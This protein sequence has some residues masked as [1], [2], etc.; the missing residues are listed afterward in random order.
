L[1]ISAAIN[2]RFKVQATSRGIVALAESQQRFMSHNT[3][4]PDKTTQSEKWAQK[5][6]LTFKLMLMSVTSLPNRERD[7][8]RFVFEPGKHFLAGKV[9]QLHARMETRDTRRGLTSR[10]AA[11]RGAAI[12]RKP[13]SKN[14][15]HSSNQT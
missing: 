1:R 15:T 5:D 11:L 10:R 3:T 12:G 4:L 7:I 14:S 6:D 2:G 13:G 8:E 9:E